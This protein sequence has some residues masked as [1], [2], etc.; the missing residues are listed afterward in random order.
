MNTHANGISP[1]LSLNRHFLGDATFFFLQLILS[2]ILRHNP[3]L[4]I[5]CFFIPSNYHC[6]YFCSVLSSFLQI[7]LGRF[8]SLWN[9]PYDF[10]TTKPT[11]W[12]CCF[13]ASDSLWLSYAFDLSLTFS[14]LMTSTLILPIGSAI[15][16]H[17]F[18][19]RVSP[20]RKCIC[21]D[22]MAVKTSVR[23]SYIYNRF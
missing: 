5:F 19:F 14:F 4:L 22:W 20:N 7:S 16:N 2:N 6:S 12:V 15:Q 11:S 23:R 1:F 17:L 21:P 13:F 18:F 10:T 8:F 3:S 9:I